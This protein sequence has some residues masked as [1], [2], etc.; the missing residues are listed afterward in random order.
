MKTDDLIKKFGTAAGIASSLGFH[1][2]TVHYWIANKNI[3]IRTQQ[4][5]QFMTGG[6]LK[7]DKAKR[8]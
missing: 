1:R 3:P 7:A 6:A 4:N 8:A 2:R 5:I